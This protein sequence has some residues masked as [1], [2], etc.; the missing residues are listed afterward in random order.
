VWVYN[1]ITL[2]GVV[3]LNLGAYFFLIKSHLVS[4][5]LVFF[6]EVEMPIQWLEKMHFLFIIYEGKYFQFCYQVV[7][8]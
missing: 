5:R 8:C 6:Y 1:L 2:V 3:D 4:H 7:L